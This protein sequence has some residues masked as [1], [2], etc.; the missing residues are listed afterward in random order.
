[1]CSS[2]PRLLDA[3]FYRQLRRIFAGENRMIV[4]VG[5]LITAVSPVMKW[6]HAHGMAAYSN[7]SAGHI[8]AELPRS[9]E[10]SEST[11]LDLLRE[12]RDLAESHGGYLILERAPESIRQAFVPLIDT[13]SALTAEL[14]RSLDPRRLLNT[15]RFGGS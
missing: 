1:M 14:A 15:G 11:L 3:S 4:R 13:N 7:I 10:I 6:M 2:P 9:D 5:V 12:L 8:M